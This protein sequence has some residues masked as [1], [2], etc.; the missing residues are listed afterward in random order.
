MKYDIYGIGNALVD[1]EFEVS[2]EFL[3]TEAIEKGMMSLIDETQQIKLLQ[4][5][6]QTITQLLVQKTTIRLNQEQSQPLQINLNIPLQVNNETTALKL[7][8]KQRNNCEADE[9]QHWEISLQFELGLLGLIRTNILLQDAKLSAHFW[10]VKPSTK[11][12]IDAHMDQFKNQ[13]KKSGFE[14]GLFDCFIGKP[15]SEDDTSPSVGE[16]LVDIK[17]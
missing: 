12:L 10:A 9:N 13:L 3:Q 6:E 16:N 1:K 17:V 5:L 4:Q 11:T 14:L 8:I 2:D 7:K 15:I